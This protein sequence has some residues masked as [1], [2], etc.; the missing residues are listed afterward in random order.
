MLRSALLSCL[1]GG[2]LSLATFGQEATSE[3]GGLDQAL[4][5]M[6]SERESENALKKSI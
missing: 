1:L 4:Q 2:C 3:P 5:D 6:L